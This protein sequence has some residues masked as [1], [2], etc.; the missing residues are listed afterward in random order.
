MN[1]DLKDQVKSYSN[2]VLLRNQLFS[3]YK[4]KN[5]VLF[6]AFIFSLLDETHK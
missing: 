6:F 4:L 5:F 2:E 3:S 1:D